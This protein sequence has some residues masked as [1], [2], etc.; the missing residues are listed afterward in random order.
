MSK[1]VVDE[2]LTDVEA[3]GWVEEAMLQ[4]SFTPNACA[5][6]FASELFGNPV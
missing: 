5:T 1:A 2:D 4:Q 3:F 6:D